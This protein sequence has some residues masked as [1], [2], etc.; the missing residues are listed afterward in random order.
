MR[1][2]HRVLAVLT[3]LFLVAGLTSVTAPA[4]AAE[5]ITR[6]ISIKG[7]EPRTN[8]FVI[9]GRVTPSTGT[10]VNIVVQVKKCGTATDC[11]KKYKTF[12]KTKTNAQGRYTQ[13]VAGPQKGVQRVYYRVKTAP[14]DKYKG[15]TSASVYIYK[16]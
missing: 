16:F 9:K 15:A 8:K 7:D 14:N 10:K 2:I 1:T 12:R 5:K 4:N 13:Q 6:E 11:K 3:G